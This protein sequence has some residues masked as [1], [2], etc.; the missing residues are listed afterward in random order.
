MTFETM[1]IPGENIDRFLRLGRNFGLA[2]YH[3]LHG[4]VLS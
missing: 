1:F 2:F 4:A 3:V